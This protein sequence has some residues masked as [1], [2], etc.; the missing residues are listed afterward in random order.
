MKGNIENSLKRYLKR[1][2]KVTLGLVVAFLITGSVGYGAVEGKLE[3]DTN[4]NIDYKVVKDNENNKNYIVNAGDL[5]AEGNITLNFEADFT[6]GSTRDELGG[7]NTTKNKITNIKAGNYVKINVVN[8][9]TVGINGIGKGGSNATTNVTAE[10][11]I[12]ILSKGVTGSNGVK[13][14]NNI[15]NL[16]AKNGNIIIGSTSTT[17]ALGGMSSGIYN[18]IGGKINL[19][20]SN[21]ILISSSTVG[22]ESHGVFSDDSGVTCLEAKEKIEIKS[23]SEKHGVTGV[24][25]REFYGSKG[26][27]ILSS[28]EISVE[29][30]SYEEKEKKNTGKNN[31]TAVYSHGGINHLTATKENGITLK[32]KASDKAEGIYS[33]GKGENILKA[34]K[35]KVV[36]SA[37]STGSISYGINSFTVP[38][39]NNIFSKVA[40]ESEAGIEINSIGK[41]DSYGVFGNVVNINL[42]SSL[43]KTSEISGNESGMSSGDIIVNSKSTD[44]MSSGLYLADSNVTVKSKNH[45]AVSSIGKGISY[46]IASFNGNADLYMEAKGNVTSYSES[47]IGN[48][49]GVF[50]SGKKADISGENIGITSKSGKEAYGL[51]VQSAPVNIK[52]DTYINV[53]GRQ[54]G[55]GRF[56]ELTDKQKEAAKEALEKGN[57]T[58]TKIFTDANLK[59]GSVTQGVRANNSKMIFDGNLTVESSDTAMTAIGEKADI[60]VNGTSN[61]TGNNYLIEQGKETTRL[62]ARPVIQALDGGDITLNGKT[63]IGSLTTEKDEAD[64]IT[65]VGVYA[66]GTTDI[67]KDSKLTSKISINGDVT[68]KSDIALMA[69]A[70]GEIYINSDQGNNNQRINKGN[71]T[72]DGDIVAGKFGSIVDVAGETVNI[73]GDIIAGN[74]GTVTV[75]LTTGNSVFT[76]KTDDYFDVEEEFGRGEFRNEKYGMDIKNSGTVIVNIDGKSIWNVDGQSYVTE[77]NFGEKGGIIN[78]KEMNGSGTT[79]SVE[80]IGGNGTFNLSLDAEDKGKGAMLYIHGAKENNLHHTVNIL[81]DSILELEVG[82]KIRFA[83]LGKEAKDSGMSFVVNE[84]KEEG[85][86]DVIFSTEHK[87]YSLYDKENEIYNGKETTENKPG[88]E[89]IDENYTGGENWFLTRAEENTEVNDGGQT[90]IEMSRANYASAVYMDNLNKR[91]G[92]MSFA[93]GNEGFWVRV[94]NDRVGED[95]EYRLIN[96]MTQLGYDSKSLVENGVSHKGIAVEY[97]T[98]D[99]EFKNIKG[100]ADIER[101]VISLYNT[102]LYNNGFYS[103][104]IVKA[105]KLDNEFD[106]NGRQ[107]GNKITGSYDNLFVGAGAEYGYRMNINEKWYFEPQAQVQYTYINNIDYMTNQNT[108]VE[109]SDVHSVIG[110][111]GFRFGY[112]RYVEENK[113]ATFYVKADINHE[114]LGEQEVRAFDKTGSIKEKYENDETWYDIGIGVSSEINEAVNVYA[115]IERQIGRTKDSNSWQF[116]LGFRYKF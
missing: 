88:D 31:A 69:T 102:K 76:G 36:I 106:I 105:G 91:L 112:D 104:Y 40:I 113:T 80:Q 114:F 93:N 72:I 115:D 66:H 100:D 11:G 52:G 44:G 45:I 90:I 74:G 43:E 29:V 108:Q 24:D 71:V 51:F 70:D 58:I 27:N 7:I 57:N 101:R 35:G 67:D 63:F 4:G 37:E 49:Y 38:S 18:A 116:N 110:R 46:G 20:N 42:I 3:P 10:N 86:K 111:T 50:I 13:A 5:S 92:D 25:S 96:Y 64:R 65:N 33:A 30:H 17:E 15:V 81:S 107:T 16:E 53:S 47:K 75:D 12:E 34:E 77:L 39:F 41:K 61:F 89:I 22:E 85:I 28:G 2:V 99:M 87:D 62:I 95:N 73:I 21:N 82:E 68:V 8:E 109:L 83:T 23:K 84:I 97:T 19:N 14:V 103:D 94:R 59:T 1:K 98:G 60:I 32:A 26:T 54:I 55:Q 48:S 9:G 78:L 79:F 56:E 6:T